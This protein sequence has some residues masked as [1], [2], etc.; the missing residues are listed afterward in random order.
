M[1]KFFKI[2]GITLGLFLVILIVAP[3]LFKGQIKDMVKRFINEN[4]NAKVEFSDVSLSLL[5]SFP[6]A[7]VSVDDLVITNLE[8]FKDETLLSAEAIA[9]EMPIK[10]LFKKANE[11]PLTVN[12]ISIEQALLTLK[13]NT[14]GNVNYDISK[15]S[16]S[17]NQDFTNANSFSFDVEDYSIKNSALTYLD[18]STGTKIHVTELM[19]SGKGVFSETNS[20]LD[21]KTEARISFGIDSTMYLQNTSI[22]LEALIGADLKNS[23]YSFKENEGFI[24][25]LPLTFQGD[26][27]LVDE[28][29]DINITF[30][31][32]G[33]TFKDFLA[34]LPSQY[35]KDLDDISTSGTFK[36]NG[37]IN[38]L[39][40]DETIP[41]LDIA[42]SSNNASFKYPDL[43]KKVENI[44]INAVLKNDDGISDNTYLD[45]KTLDFKIDQDIFKSSTT[46]KNLTKNMLVN[47]AIDGVLNLGNISKAY[48]IDLDKDMSGILKGK[49]QLDFDMNA[50]ETN[51][52]ERI[53]S[54]GNLDVMNFVFSS[55]DIVNPIKISDASLTFNPKK[56]TLKSFN[57]TTGNSDL[58]ATGTIT[59]LLGFL[60]SD[61][62]LQGN[63]NVNS[64]NF[65]VSD[66][67]I[68]DTKDSNETTSESESLK[69]PA[70]LDC[71]INANAK[72][73][74]Y[75]NL[76]L[77]NV[78]GLMVIKDEKAELKNMSSNIFDGD[79]AIS[80][81]VDTKPKTPTFNMSLG[82]N[83]FD[84]S[85]SFNQLDLLQNLA[86]IAKALKGKLN[87][88]IKLSGLLDNEF[89]PNLQTVSGNAL[90]ELLTTKIE[91]KNAAI[92]N[93]LGDNINF[94]D[95]EKLDLKNLKTD[96]SFKDGQVAIKPFNLK[97]QDIDITIEGSHGFDKS[98]VYN[99]VFDVPAKYLGSEVNRL[100]GKIN[101]E[102]VNDISIPVTANIGGTFTA[103]T[104]KTDLT[105]GVSALTQKLIEI[106]KQKLINKGKD[107]LGD[108]LGDI[109]NKPKDST[110][111]KTDSTKTKLEE[112]V[113]D[114]LGNLLKKKKTKKDTIKE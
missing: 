28:G 101:N 91:P 46:I 65:A 32:S 78:K 11:G 1:K 90:A 82:M 60:L 4:V 51:A 103:P 108:V 85:Q 37:K 83:S 71:S 110:K 43:P 105:S 72:T 58:D 2:L 40:S 75:D 30:E 74:L 47:T 114:V 66:F 54:N 35:A 8:P 10:E 95:F 70:F 62:K 98:L 38:G 15:P 17:K 88:S 13:T 59:N 14:L 64:N 39:L 57:A 69:I 63:F 23:V 41:K 6:Q 104:V 56:V 5:S 16:E 45:I 109:F 49:L 61:G 89:K 50:L 52:F 21:T 81:L 9:F 26:V 96:I 80:G 76:T 24:N 25:Q 87:T 33:S 100:I 68:E 29:Q 113:K 31:N 111:T 48:P 7:K 86:P 3:M 22:K 97:Y 44:N 20:E 99:A 73:V 107:K 34:V 112:G 102:S 106:E 79:L 93:L 84:I 53:K 18:E 27:K 77:K 36:V 42:V 94:I 67:M 12:A 92:L 19:H 55:Q